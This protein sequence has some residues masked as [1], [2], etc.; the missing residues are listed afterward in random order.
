MS[1]KYAFSNSDSDFNEDDFYR[2]DEADDLVD[3]SIPSRS[4]VLQMG[5]SGRHCDWKMYYKIHTNKSYSLNAET[6]A[7]GTAF[8]YYF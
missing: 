6:G 5:F 1:D 8:I 2:S 3:L 7:I 4:V